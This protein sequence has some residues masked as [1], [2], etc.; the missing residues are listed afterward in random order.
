MKLQKHISRKSK[1]GEDYFKW[2]V[3]LSKEAIEKAGFKEGD[4]LEEDAEKG[5]IVLKKRERK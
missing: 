3:I 4:E 1:L 5:K 2:E